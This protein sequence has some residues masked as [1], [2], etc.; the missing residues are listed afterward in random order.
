MIS[1]VPP[2]MTAQEY[3]DG[4]I[5]DVIYDDDDDDSDI[6]LDEEPRRTQRRYQFLRHM[7]VTPQFYDSAGRACALHAGIM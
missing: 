2:L 3:I 4:G 1:S 7:E 6:G 5:D